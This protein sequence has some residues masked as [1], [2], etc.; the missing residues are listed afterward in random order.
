MA[1]AREWIGQSTA[2]D[3]LDF[4]TIRAAVAPEAAFLCQILDAAKISGLFKMR[5]EASEAAATSQNWFKRLSVVAVISTAIATLTSG[6]LLYGAGSEAST[7]APVEGLVR[8][9]KDNHYIIVGFQI[10]ALFF[11][12]VVTSVLASQNYVERWQEQRNRAELL[13]RQIFNEILTMAEA[14]VPSQLATAD[15]TNPIAQAFEFFRRYQHELQINFYGR[16]SVRHARAAEGLGWLTAILAGLAAVTGVLGAFGGWTLILS[17]F[18][19]IAVP[20]LLS[21]AQSWRVSS[22][23]SDKLAAYQKAKEA[24]D[25]NLLNIDTVR[26][27]ATMGDAAAVGAYVNTVHLIMT[28]ENDAWT[29]AAKT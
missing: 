24:L 13:R 22:R 2:G 26:A 20:I 11:A 27:R 18:L 28:T 6:L 29:P 9:V 10:A 8:G 21:A 14:E 19:G 16:G 7:T 15:P 5:T 12:G 3:K 25:V 23:D 1:N 17:A 4:A